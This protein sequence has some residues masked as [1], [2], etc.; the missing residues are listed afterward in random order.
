MILSLVN[1]T[2]KVTEVVQY[3]LGKAKEG[4]GFERE[5]M[6]NI[7]S[8]ALIKSAAKLQVKREIRPPKIFRFLVYNGPVQRASTQAQTER[9]IKHRQSKPLSTSIAGN[10]AR[11]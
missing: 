3:D 8:D 5:G 7:S 11:A 2:D 6:L 1:L 10:Q 4:Y 9:A